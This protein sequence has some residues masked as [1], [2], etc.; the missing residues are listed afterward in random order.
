[1]PGR[2]TVRRFAIIGL[3]A[4]MV[5]LIADGAA[6]VFAQSPPFGAPRAPASPPSSATGIVAFG[7]LLLVGYMGSERLIGV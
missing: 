7:V 1:M 2:L 5:L 6:L 4:V 3:A